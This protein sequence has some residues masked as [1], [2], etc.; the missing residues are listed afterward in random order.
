MKR[1]VMLM[2]N[3][4]H[5][6]SLPATW[7]REHSVTKGQQLEVVEDV[8][9][10]TVLAGLKKEKRKFCAGIAEEIAKAYQQGYDEV[11]AG[12]S[13]EEVERM[14]PSLPGFEIVKSGKECVVQALSE[15]GKK[16]F[17]A[18]FRRILL[19][20]PCYSARR[21]TLTRLV[22]VCKRSVCR[23]GCGSLVDSILAYN[24]LC[25]IEKVINSKSRNSNVICRLSLEELGKELKEMSLK[26]KQ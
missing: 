14:L 21:E 2:G 13:V 1:N 7:V 26:Q 16:E 25:D 19:L 22:N 9:K 4:T 12:C 24:A 17:W 8:G 23:Q 15:I 20:L 11:K 18:L 6:I 10:V 5:V 3:K